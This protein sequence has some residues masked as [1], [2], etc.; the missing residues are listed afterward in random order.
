MGEL[1]PDGEVEARQSRGL[2]ARDVLIQG[3][4]EC[5]E[6]EIRL[7]LC[8]RAGKH[9]LTALLGSATELVKQPRLPDPRFADELHGRAL[10]LLEAIE[11]RVDHDDGVSPADERGLE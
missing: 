3:I 5:R 10:A 9:E 2:Q 11:E 6:G 1:G 7:E 4:H 8:G